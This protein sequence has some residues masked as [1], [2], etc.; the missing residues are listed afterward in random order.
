LVN[1]TGFEW[2]NGNSLKNWERHGV[3]QSEC[4][5][6]F[7]NEPLIVFDD[8]KHSSNEKRWFL[9]GRTDTGR[10]LFLVFTV[11]KN[12]LR[13]ISARYMN[14]KERKIYNEKA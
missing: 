6:V 8:V 14:K 4:E 10:F 12:L 11:R 13:V 2:D 3:S 9:L 7:F 5:Q 1:C